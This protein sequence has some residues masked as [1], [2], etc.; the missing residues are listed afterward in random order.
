VS[1]LHI[2]SFEIR[3]DEG[4]LAKTDACAGTFLLVVDLHAKEMACRA[5]IRNLI[6]SLKRSTIFREV[7]VNLGSLNRL[8]FW[9]KRKYPCGG[10][11]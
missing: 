8:P 11:I 4:L 5:E 6:F 3:G 9:S 1:M 7:F 10:C 2:E